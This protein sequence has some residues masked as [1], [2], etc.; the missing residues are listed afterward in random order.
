MKP[1]NCDARRPL[2]RAVP[3]E[4]RW[5]LHPPGMHTGVSGARPQQ[6]CRRSRRRRTAWPTRL[7]DERVQLERLT[8]ATIDP[9]A[10]G[11]AALLVALP[12]VRMSAAPT[13]A[14]LETTAPEL[15][16]KLLDGRDAARR[17]RPR[18]ARQ[19]AAAA[20]ARDMALALPGRRQAVVR[21]STRGCASG[22]VASRMMNAV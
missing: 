14:P 17:E 22:R 7:V 3:H 19:A 18:V 2:R 5:L 12:V 21:S 4:R 1:V 8:R 20:R 9:L 13:H 10:S 15:A 6:R 16:V 11:F